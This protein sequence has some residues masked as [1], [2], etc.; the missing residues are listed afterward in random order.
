MREQEESEVKVAGGGW[1]WLLEGR[2]ANAHDHGQRVLSLSAFLSFPFFLYLTLDFSLFPS[3]LCQ[4][5]T[6][7]PP[8]ARS[9]YFPFPV[10]PPRP[11]PGLFCTRLFV[12]PGVLCS[13]VSKFPFEAA[14]LHTGVR[15]I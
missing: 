15:P 13:C 10:S 9:F 2:R 7:P 8:T 1:W 5:S 3:P 14:V 11:S 6:S 12:E 4:P